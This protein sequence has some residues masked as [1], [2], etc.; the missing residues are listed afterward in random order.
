[1]ILTLPKLQNSP[2]FILAW[3]ILVGQPSYR[4]RRSLDDILLIPLRFNDGTLS[5]TDARGQ[6][7]LPI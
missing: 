5:W 6:E 3:P 7:W 4:Q 2:K 1:M